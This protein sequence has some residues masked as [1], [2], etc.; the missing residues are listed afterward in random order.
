MSRSRPGSSAYL[1]PALTTVCLDF[2]WQLEQWLGSADSAHLNQENVPSA[3]T[4]A[5][6]QANSDLS[7]AG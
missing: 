6:N 3:L 7:T 1:S 5:A 2:A 4:K